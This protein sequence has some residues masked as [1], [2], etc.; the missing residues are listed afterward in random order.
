M[1]AYKQYV[2]IK[3]PAKVELNG[4]PFRAG[5][6]VEVVMIAENDDQATR[7][8][9]LR[10]LFRATQALPQAQAI[11]DETIAEEVESYRVGR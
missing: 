9:E 2:T 8:E 4:L 6:R 7:S 10:A 5:Q 3:D 1:L 11:T